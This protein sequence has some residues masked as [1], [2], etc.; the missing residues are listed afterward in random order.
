MVFN[1]TCYVNTKTND[2][3]RLNSPEINSH[4][5][6][7]HGQKRRISSSENFWCCSQTKSY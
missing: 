2:S 4:T 3:N 7:P 1:G 5:C 6:A